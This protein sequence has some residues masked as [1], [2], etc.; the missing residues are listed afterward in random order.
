MWIF[1]QNKKKC[2]IIYFI[3][4]E[5]LLVKLIQDILLTT[6]YS[7]MNDSVLIHYHTL[8]YWN[9][10]FYYEVVKMVKYYVCLYHFSIAVPRI[11]CQN[12]LYY[13]LFSLWLCHTHCIHTCNKYK[14]SIL[15]YVHCQHFGKEPTKCKLIFGRLILT[16]LIMIRLRWR[17]ILY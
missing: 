2:H 6:W 1:Q 9:L 17:T 11:T 10:L 3:A 15:W 12:Q 5:E 14:H 8:L 13:I 7:S 4:K 16:V